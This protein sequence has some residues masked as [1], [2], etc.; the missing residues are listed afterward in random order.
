MLLGARV[1]LTALSGRGRAGARNL[2]GSKSGDSVVVGN[3]QAM[4]P[5]GHLGSSD[6][7][8]EMLACRELTSAATKSHVQGNSL[9]FLVRSYE[10]PYGY[11]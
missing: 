4:T 3:T 8:E 2:G 11:Q 5:E 10:G 7:Q 6:E 1:W 9:L